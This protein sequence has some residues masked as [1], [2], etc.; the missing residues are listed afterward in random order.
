M[1]KIYMNGNFYTFDKIKPHVESVVVENGRFIDMGST[2]SMV[3]QW[4]RA[5]AEI[6]NLEGKT[7]TPGLI[8]SH[9]HVAGIAK[10]FLHL[11]VTGVTSKSEMLEK[12]KEKGKTLKE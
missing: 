5:S 10:S 4:D 3:H 1:R 7:A 6:I 8:D 2:K 11:D 9:L 12:I